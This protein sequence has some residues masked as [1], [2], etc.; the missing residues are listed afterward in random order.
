MRISIKFCFS[1]LSVSRFQVINLRSIRPLDMHTI[2]ESVKKTNHLIS[3]EGGWPQ[4]GV[5]SEILA[6][7]FECKKLFI[8][9][10]IAN[11]LN[12]YSVL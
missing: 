11:G 12:T 9:V 3:V 10:V 4:S 8:A 1:T 5:G 6:Q 2:V 7:V